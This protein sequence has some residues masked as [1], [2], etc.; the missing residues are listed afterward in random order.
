MAEEPLSERPKTYVTRRGGLYVKAEE[1]LHSRKA[2]AI[3]DKMASLPAPSAQMKDEGSQEKDS[4]KT[5]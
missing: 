2:R 1:L 3:I 4:K 5:E